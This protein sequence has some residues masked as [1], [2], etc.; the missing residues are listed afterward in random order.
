[1]YG[2][3]AYGFWKT[4]AHCDQFIAAKQVVYGAIPF[5]ITRLEAVL[6][7]RW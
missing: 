5:P 1:M 3:A 2:Y 4:E 6:P 7:V